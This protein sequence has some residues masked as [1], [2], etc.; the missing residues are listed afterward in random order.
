MGYHVTITRRRDGKN[1][2]ISKKE[3]ENFVSLSSDL[4]LEKLQDG[5]IY[6]VW[7]INNEIIGTLG[8]SYG[9]IWTKNPEDKFLAKMIEIANRLDARVQGDEGEYYRT[10]QDAY[11]DPGEKEKQAVELKKIHQKTR[12]K[13]FILNFVIFLFFLLLAFIA[14]KYSN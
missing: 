9:E 6:T 3:W 5:N 8:W 14:S 1:N 2:P 7:K 13:T 4:S 10:V 12:I 11:Y